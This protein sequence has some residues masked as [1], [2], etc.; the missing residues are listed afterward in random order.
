MIQRRHG[1]QYSTPAHGTVTAGVP[2]AGTTRL[3]RHAGGPAS[4]SRRQAGVTAGRTRLP[5]RVEPG[6]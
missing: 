5:G 3:P 1:Y 4:E 6:L 2:Y